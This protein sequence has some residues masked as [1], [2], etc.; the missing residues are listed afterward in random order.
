MFIN[1]FSNPWSWYIAGPLLGLIVPILLILGNKSFGVS[2][3]LRHI[4]AIVLPSKTP[5]FLYDW[6]KEI[7]SLL[8]VLGVVIGGFI[9]VVL[10]PNP[11]PMKLATQTLSFLQDMHVDFNEG[12]L[13]QNLFS[14]SSLITIKGFLIIVVGGFMVG[15]GTR[16]A[17]GCTSGHGI[18]GIANLQWTSLLATISFFTGGILFSHFVL[19]YILKL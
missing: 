1:W 15:F 8:F 2:S 11:Q 13:P 4:C 5:L 14:W 18:L 12:L 3:S 6:K 19:P 10:F 9:S 7:W 17:G 16:Y